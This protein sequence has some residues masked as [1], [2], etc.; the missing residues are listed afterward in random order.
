MAL[1]PPRAPCPRHHGQP[2][3]RPHFWIQP[4]HWVKKIRI[5]QSILNFG[6]RGLYRGKKQLI[7]TL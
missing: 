7:S 1:H 5:E 6:P 4:Q 2:P 3:A